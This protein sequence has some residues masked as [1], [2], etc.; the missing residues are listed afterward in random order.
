[1]LPF[2]KQCSW[3]IKMLTEEIS[4]KDR[5]L[6]SAKNRLLNL[7]NREVLGILL[8]LFVGGS[9]WSLGI[10]LTSD[11]ANFA[12]WG[13]SW[14][15][16]FSTEM[17]GAFLTF[18]LL[19][20]VVGSRQQREAELKAEQQLK[21][22]LI[23]QMR[24]QDNA[25]ALQAL[26]EL[27]AHGW[28]EDG[29]LQG[30]HLWGA[31]L[32]GAGLL[33]AN[34]QGASLGGANLQGANLVGANLQGARLSGANLQGADLKYANLQRAQLW[35]AKLQRSHLWIANLQGA[36][37]VGA[38][39]QGA[40]L[41]QVNLQQAVLVRANLQGAKLQS[42]VFDE[43][44]LLPDG[45]RWTPDTDMTQFTQPDKEDKSE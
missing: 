25:I 37:L 45:T 14:L 41:Y 6:T 1:M 11:H 3:G 40:E 38:N 19:E 2:P 28:L 21:Q 24:S 15:Q 9:L 13:E 8:F 18:I 44:T 32:Q 7:S 39:L 22:R 17:F 23:I 35:E 29:S 36:N 26:D 31:N 33:Q 16:N 42:A 27:D 4:L 12:D 30:A 34:L 10:N 20:L 43:D 5:L